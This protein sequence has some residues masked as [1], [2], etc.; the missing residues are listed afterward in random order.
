MPTSRK[1][2]MINTIIDAFFNIINIEK[3][4]ESLRQELALCSDYNIRDH[5]RLVVKSGGSNGKIGTKCLIKQMEILE[6]DEEI[7]DKV[8]DLVSHFDINSN[9]Y[10]SMNEFSNLVCPIQ[11]EY[12]ELLNCRADTQILD[13]QELRDVRN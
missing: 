5:F 11:K 13:E 1:R 8:S 7:K 3:E 12:R 9:G 4:L 6:M 2:K 10:L